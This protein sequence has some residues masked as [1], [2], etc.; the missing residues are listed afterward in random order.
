MLDLFLAAAAAFLYLY[1]LIIARAST[2]LRAYGLLN[3]CAYG[4]LN[5]GAVALRS[6]NEATNQRGE[7][8]GGGKGEG[9]GFTALRRVLVEFNTMIVTRHV[10]A[11]VSLC[12]SEVRF[13]REWRR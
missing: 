1:A 5:F 12:G 7:S 11:M 8:A 13:R 4:G 9:A 6:V 3:S 2:Y 10:S